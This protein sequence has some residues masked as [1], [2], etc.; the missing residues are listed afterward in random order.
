MESPAVLTRER[1][2]AGNRSSVPRISRVGCRSGT[3]WLPLG[4]GNSYRPIPGTGKSPKTWGIEVPPKLKMRFFS[5]QG[6]QGST[7]GQIRLWGE[8]LPN[9]AQAGEFFTFAEGNQPTHE[10][11]LKDVPPFPKVPGRCRYFPSLAVTSG[12][13][14]F[15]P[16]TA[17]RKGLTLL[18]FER[19]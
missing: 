1:S 7:L 11:P 18:Q 4:R 3:L 5:A 13:I 16:R 8:D 17:G 12:Y 14:T 10:A 19:S 9:D 15:H 2:T 6:A